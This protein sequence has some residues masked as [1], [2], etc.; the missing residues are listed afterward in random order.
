MEIKFIAEGL[1]NL[2]LEPETEINLY[3]I[4]QEALS[5]VKR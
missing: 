1:G 4:G 3:R 2:E 5:N